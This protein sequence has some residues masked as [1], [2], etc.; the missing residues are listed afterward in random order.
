M[1]KIGK[2]IKVTLI[3][4][5][6]VCFFNS[7]FS[8]QIFALSEH[9]G[10]ISIYNDR[11]DEARLYFIDLD[12]WLK[13]RLW[14]NTYAKGVYKDKWIIYEIY[15]QT[16]WNS[17]SY[18][19]DIRWITEKKLFDI[20]IN[21]EGYWYVVNVDKDTGDF[22]YFLYENNTGN[23]TFYKK[24]VLNTWTWEIVLSGQWKRFNAIS[25]DYNNIIYNSYNAEVW[26][27]V[28]YLKNLTTW[29]EIFL[30]TWQIN[31]ENYFSND[32]YRFTEAWNEIIETTETFNFET[33]I[34]TRQ[35]WFIDISDLSNLI[36]TSVN[37]DLWQYWQILWKKWTDTY[38]T[39]VDNNWESHTY[40][41][42]A[43]G[44]T[45]ILW[46]GKNMLFD[47]STWKLGIYEDN[48]LYNFR[49]S[50]RNT[51]V[52]WYKNINTSE[53]WE[54]FDA[55]NDYNS[56]YLRPKNT[57]TN[58][59]GTEFCTWDL[60]LC[61]TEITNFLQIWDYIY[62]SY[63]NKIW[64]IG[65]SYE[66]R[67]FQTNLPWV[68]WYM[69]NNYNFTWW[70]ASVELVSPIWY[71]WNNYTF[72]EETSIAVSQ[73]G[74]IW[75]NYKAILPN[76]HILLQDR[77]QLKKSTPTPKKT[78]KAIIKNEKIN[79][80]TTDKLDPVNL[81]TGEFTYDNTLMHLQ[82]IGQSYELSISYRSRI[83]TETSL[84]MNWSHNYDIRLVDNNDGTIELLDWKLWTQTII[85]S[86]SD[87]QEDTE[88]DLQD[89]DAKLTK[90]SN[91]W[92]Y[93]LT[94]K[95]KKV[96]N[97][98]TNWQL[99]SIQDPNWNTIAFAYN[100]DNLLS[101]ITDTLWRDIKYTYDN[102]YKLKRVT[103]PEWRYVEFNYFW[104]QE[105]DWSL[106]DLESVKI[107][108]SETKEKTIN[109]TYYKNATDNKLS[110]NIK[111]LSDSKWQIYVTN[112]YDTN[113]RVISQT[114]WDWTWTYDYTLANIHTD[115]T[116]ESVW[117][118]TIIW[119]YVSK[120]KV[121]D[122]RWIITEYNYNRMWN[123]ITRTIFNKVDPTK[124]TIT[125]YEYDNT[126]RMTKEIYP[127]WNAVTY[128]YDT[129]WN[130]IETRQKTNTQNPDDDELDLVTTYEY[131]QSTNL[132]TKTIL[133]NNTEIEFNYDSNNNLIKTETKDIKLWLT[134]SAV[135]LI[136]ENEYNWSWQLT[137]TI[138]PENNE[139]NIEYWSWQ[140][141]KII[142]WTE[143]NQIIE[144]YNYDNYWNLISKTDWELHTQI[145]TYDELNRI[146]ETT[147]AEWITRKYEYDQ[148][149]N[150][151][152][153][154]L[155]L[156]ESNTVN[157]NYTYN[158]LDKP[159]QV[160]Q[161]ISPT[162]NQTIQTIYDQNENIT[163]IT[164]ANW[165]KKQFT[166]NESNKVTQ[167]KTIPTEW[168]T[169]NIKYEYDIN[170][171]KTKIIDSK[172]NETNIE[173][174]LFDRPTKQI[175]SLWN[176]ITYNYDKL[177]KVI[178][179]NTYSSTN[180]KIQQTKITYNEI[181]QIL[182][183]ET[184]DLNPDWTPKT[185]NPQNIITSLEY[186]K[187]WQIIK[188]ID[189]KWNTTTI[190]Y[191][192]FNRPI[193]TIDPKNNKTE[194]T[195]D[196]NNN[197]TQKQIIQNNGKTTTTIYIYDK[198]NR[199]TSSKQILNWQDLINELT[200]NKL[201][202]VIKS[203]DANGNE[204]N[205]TYDY[206]W[207]VLSETKTNSWTTIETNYTY[208]ISWNLIK[209]IDSNNNETN[210]V[211]NKLNQLTKQIY[212]DNREINYTYDENGNLETTQDPN[213]TITTNTYD[214]LNRLTWKTIQKWEWVEWITSETYIY[215]AL[216]RLIQAN[217][218][219]NHILDFNYDS[220]NRLI[221]ENN[222]W[223]QV[224][225]TYDENNNLTSVWNT[226]YTYDELNRVTSIKQNNQEVANYNYSWL[227]NT[228][229]D[230]ANGE[231][232]TNTYDDLNRLQTLNNSIKN[233]T[234]T[235]DNVS[236]ILSDNNKNYT[237]DDIYRLTQVNDTNTSIL[238]EYF[239]Y[240][241]VWNRLTSYNQATGSWA[242][243]SYTN[244]TLNQYTSLSWSIQNYELQEIIEEIQTETQ[245]ESGTIYGTW[246]QITYSWSLVTVNE[247]T[248]YIYDNNWNITN[249][250]TNTY[251]YD[252]KNR[253][254]KVQNWTWI[255]VEF[256]YDVVWRRYQKITQE[257]SIN[258]IYSWQQVVE[259]ITTEN[260]TQTQTT[261]EYIY[262]N[263]WVDDV[264]AYVENWNTYY[265]N[266]DHLWSTIGITDNSW[267][268]ITEY[269]YDSFWN[270]TQS[271]TDLWYNRMFTGRDY[272]KEI[273][274]YYLRARYYSSNL[275]RFISRD[276]IDISDDVNLYAYVGNN[277]VMFVD[278]MGLEKTLIIWFK[279]L[280]LTWYWEIE[281]ND[282]WRDWVW[283][284]INDL[285]FNDS[286]KDKIDYK[287]YDSTPLL[288]G[289]IWWET[290]ALDYILENK[291]K[292]NKIILL[293]HSQWADSAV[294]LSNSLDNNDIKVDLL[295]TVDLQAI[296]DTTEVN[297]NTYL[298]IN[299][300]QTNLLSSA[301]GDTLW[302]AQNNI[303]TTLYNIEQNDYC[304]VYWCKNDSEDYDFWHTN[305]DDKLWSKIL[306]NI[307]SVINN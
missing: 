280:D 177:G 155:V 17:T 240:D 76:W 259:E 34:Q 241:K 97:F 154:S 163:E 42:T 261:K 216:W 4:F 6:S 35:N 144:I 65:S 118:W 18:Y 2:Y 253:L 127:K 282:Y 195:Y 292:Y 273:G 158:L 117:N 26:V 99:T 278:L 286:Y 140:I 217:D 289:I 30:W 209:L 271:W 197:I 213:G 249:D 204:I 130:K 260:T 256:K 223:E 33:W 53:I 100:Q 121:T 284:I 285:R 235:Y 84:W 191:D 22:I 120:N 303:I 37:I 122:K 25:G 272:D 234:Y 19:R 199:L 81:N 277:P 164:Y 31:W 242:D 243:Y 43:T 24:N 279:W 32:N 72:V 138:D 150:K 283:S 136:T 281:T 3:T 222:S 231:S 212:P 78:E 180:L 194:T 70:V 159:T 61:W 176:Y 95:N 39:S 210:Y 137:K 10:W 300:Y 8:N 151:I 237:Y 267:T 252:Y 254:L 91:N 202:N 23:Q 184:I 201:W 21:W 92:W 52:T 167:E 263:W 38:Y 244:N 288:W 293:W 36:Y 124:Q 44:D 299:Y 274:L 79:T 148:N 179:T 228:S 82:W 106:Y 29:Q 218:S 214:N 227:Q 55:N 236:T 190:N 112:A 219:D 74:Y 295:I 251:V 238:L 45:E 175:D 104:D 264:V 220:L 142:K 54:L 187:N 193:E 114:Y 192:I 67:N 255:I 168:Q 85:W 232:I 132:L 129:N 28:N 290:Q 302:L 186:N 304:S 56:I 207:K 185:E 257:E 110:N 105:T 296:Y 291:S 75:N 5:I 153:D 49:D 12:T 135:S 248:V 48:I 297:N 224:D 307:I 27:N 188:Q 157:T 80:K 139:T 169:T 268:I 173:Y 57:S 161:D 59:W 211:Y 50:N 198:D 103:E 7:F 196:K 9:F 287:Y 94:Y 66:E 294:E 41:N 178:E 96:Y 156:D 107:H 14:I 246:T 102:T 51:S 131:D 162:Q 13:T 145:L 247:T 134:T 269:I 226:T 183:Q 40:I 233:Y 63:S 11:N 305:I 174:D 73:I 71:M 206:R 200:Y 262:W 270:F 60:S 146:K 119:T 215:D 15:D 111:T 16:L 77:Y 221:W 166:Y 265:I 126:W 298:A 133:P 266:K 182:K 58:T 62:K 46:N 123:V 170:G 208:D 69:G 306:D 160:T 109:F 68:I 275:W 147:S 128:K 90:Y 258:Y 88:I 172:L 165:T 189:P 125:S 250:W 149:D 93:K 229:I 47:R 203:K 143:W 116:P 152:L 276:P 225:Y 101:D 20:P 108:N 83:Q 301:N 230:Y 98:N 113:D 239:N 86:G 87:F 1:S 89:L 171:N 245:T 64:Y 205:Y 115:D 141:T 181:W